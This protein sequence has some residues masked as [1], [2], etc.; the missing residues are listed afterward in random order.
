MAAN[1]IE[2]EANGVVRH[3]WTQPQV[4]ALFGEPFNDLLLKAQTLHR[5]FFPPNRVQISTLLSVKTGGCP[6]DCGYCPQ[7]VHFDTGVAAGAL[8]DPAGVLDAA[9]TAKARAPP[10][11]AW[12]PPTAVPS[13]P[14]SG[15]WRT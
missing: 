1:L 14:R 12:G 15:P 11:S 2:Y 8:L 13:R 10:G 5:R 3:D 7:S 6:E 9:R 4:N